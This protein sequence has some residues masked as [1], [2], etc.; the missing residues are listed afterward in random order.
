VKKVMPMSP[1]INWEELRQISM[2]PEPPRRAGGESGNMWDK[3][4]LMY[5]EMS[6]M[7]KSYT[8]NQINAFETAPDDSVLDIGCG[9]GRISIPMAQ[10]AARVTAIDSAEK[11]LAFCRQNVLEAGVTN[12]N[13]RLLDWK[14]AV[15][16][17]NLE[18]HDIVIA[19][20]SPGMAD[21][22]KTSSFARK[23]VVLIAW[24]NAPNIPMILGDLFEGVNPAQRLPPR[25]VDRRVGYNLTYNMVYDMGYEPNVRIVT[26]GFTRD[27]SSREEAYGDLWR[28]REEPGTIPAPFKKNADKWLFEGKNGGVTF[29]RET[30]SFVMWWETNK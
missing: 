13:V 25:P 12:L 17:Q 15:L 18:Q 24:A 10:R 4:A 7:E 5:N 26:D 20:R 22:I 16:G 3:S 19:S 27:Y 11:I 8:L 6:K 28:L 2:P 9:A 14:D 23:L 1:L 30:R 21:L 29:R